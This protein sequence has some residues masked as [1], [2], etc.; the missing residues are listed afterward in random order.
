[1]TK[2]LVWDLFSSADDSVRTETPGDLF[3]PTEE[4]HSRMARIPGK[5]II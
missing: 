4:H 2:I 1:V 3:P 5:L